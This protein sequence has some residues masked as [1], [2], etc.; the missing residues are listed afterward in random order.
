[1]W[2]ASSRMTFVVPSIVQVIM[3]KMALCIS[4]LANDWTV[5]REVIAC[6][7]L[8]VIMKYQWEEEY[9]SCLPYR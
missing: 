3:N 5:E 8:A 2:S 4:I 9:L 1:M 6:N 7:V